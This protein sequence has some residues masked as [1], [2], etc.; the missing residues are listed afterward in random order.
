MSI[1][2]C[3]ATQNAGAQNS[4]F[5]HTKGFLNTVGMYTLLSS[6]SSFYAH[7]K[8]KAAITEGENET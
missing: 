2:R 8:R 4:A 7:N 3:V 1:E 5:L 6:I